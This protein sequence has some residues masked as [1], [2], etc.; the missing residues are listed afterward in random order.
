MSCSQGY[1]QKMWTKAYEVGISMSGVAQ[2][3]EAAVRSM[4]GGARR[5]VEG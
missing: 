4:R 5:V 1:A 3:G 2:Q